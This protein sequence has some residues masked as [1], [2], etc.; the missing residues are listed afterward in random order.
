MLALLVA[1]LPLL[2][3]GA[4][5]QCGPRRDN[6][7]PHMHNNVHLTTTPM[8]F[9]KSTG[10]TDSAYQQAVKGTQLASTFLGNYGPAYTFLL[11]S[12][13]I[14]AV[15]LSRGSPWTPCS[16]LRSRPP[17]GAQRQRRG[18]RAGDRSA[19]RVRAGVLRV[20][21]AAQRRQPDEPG[22]TGPRR[23]LHERPSGMEGRPPLAVLPARYR[24]S[25]APTVSPAAQ[26]Q[27]QLQPAPTF[28]GGDEPMRTSPA[29]LVAL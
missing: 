1:L 28:A 25:H 20:L 21:A 18:V 3:H 14:L 10:T 29:A 11:V 2:L 19:V 23:L 26:P 13:R 12:R 6:N 7:S 27:P 22:Q 5:A 24:V 15:P 8:R 9:A 16:L 17:P 4:A